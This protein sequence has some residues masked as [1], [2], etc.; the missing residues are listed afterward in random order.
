MLVGQKN[1]MDRL[2]LGLVDSGHILLEGVPGLAKML[3]R[4]TMAAATQ[5]RFHR[6]QL[7]PDM[8][9]AD[10]IGTMTCNPR[11]RSFHTKAP[12]RYIKSIGF[13]SVLF[14]KPGLSPGRR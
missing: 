9:P 8:L 5:L 10:I 11:N 14:R 1:P 7:T 13:I 3:S 6:L 4:K 12:G 2:L